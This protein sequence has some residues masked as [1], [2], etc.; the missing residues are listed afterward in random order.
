[1]E[2]RSSLPRW[3]AVAIALTAPL[4]LYRASAAEPAYPTRPVRLVVPYPPSGGTDLVARMLGQKM[5]ETWHY[6]VVIDNRAGGSAI[7][8]TDI[9]AKAS[10]DGYTLL[11]GSSSGMVLNPLLVSDLPYNAAKDFAPISLTSVNAFVLVV[12]PQ[13]AA[14]SIAELVALAK[15]KPGQLNYAS[16]GYNTP[17][18][19]AVE[20]FKAVTGTDIVHVPYKGSEPALVDIMAGHVQMKFNSISGVVPLI[21]ANKLKALAIA[22]P[23]RSRVLPNVPTMAEAGVPNFEAGTWEAMYAPAR[24]PKPIL[25]E[26]SRQVVKALADPE[27]AKRIADGGAEPHGSTPEQLATYTRDETARWKL[28]IKNTQQK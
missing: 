26:I 17:A 10:P 6:Q 25:D 13:L 11:M 14:N 19:L 8:G 21:R 16:P 18:Q 23:Q 20:M 1:M 7:I 15:A 5:S 3:L 27:V 9:V 22:T 12:S 2:S 28:A 4:A 24:T